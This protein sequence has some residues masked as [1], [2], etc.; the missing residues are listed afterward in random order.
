MGI[1]T[2][3]NRGWYYAL[4]LVA[5][6]PVFGI[7]LTSVFIL[8]LSLFSLILIIKEYKT[9]FKKSNLKWV[10]LFSSTYI[11][12]LIAALFYPLDHTSGFILEKKMSLLIFPIILFLIPNN[13]EKDHFRKLLL[14]FVLASIGITIYTNIYISIADMPLK[15]SYYGDT[16]YAYRSFFEEI[17]GIHPTY[18]SLYLAF[19]ALIL[20]DFGFK[21]KKNLIWYGIAFI[22][23]VASLIP[24]AAKLPMIAFVISFGLYI[25]IQ[26][27]IWK[28]TK[29]LF[30]TLIAG[31]IITVLTVPALKIRVDEIINS[32]FTPPQGEVYNSINIRCGIWECSYS[33]VKENWIM[34]IGSGQI[35]EQLNSCYDK[36]DTNAYSSM[37]YNTHNEY[38]DILLSTGIIG[39][40]SF[41]F[42]IVVILYQ[43]LKNKN[44]LF[45]SFIILVL[46]CLT[47][48]NILARQGGI[49][50]FTF[51]ICLFTKHKILQEKNK[52]D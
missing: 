40:L 27:H 38:F 1:N 3:L 43:S 9:S 15:Y 16:S 32:S 17:S 21:E 44:Y 24:L 46:L 11:I 12:Y 6:F 14:G 10:L 33:L 5:V 4:F 29:Y 34:G 28:K 8:L 35:Q 48:E 2:F 42:M 13:I 26:P 49:V 18:I 41:L 23:C 31:I 37:D 36:Y 7:K 51:F 22:I 30:F 25:I 39:L 45:F 50:F 52:I 47:T 20:V 19:S